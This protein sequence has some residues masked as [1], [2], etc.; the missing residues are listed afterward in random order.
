MTATETLR[1]PLPRIF[2]G[3]ST[4]GLPLAKTLQRL[5]RD[6]AD[7]SLWSD[8]VF[9]LSRAF[10]ESLES[11]LDHADFA[12]MAFT[13]DDV[14]TSRDQAHA[15]PRDNVLF[16]LGLFMGRLGRE[17]CYFVHDKADN[18]KLPSDL[19]G[20]NP[21]NFSLA[22]DGDLAAS[23]EDVVTHIRERLATLGCRPKL[24]DQVLDVFH[25]KQA[26][27][28]AIEG[29]WWQRMLPDTQSALG[30][31]TLKVEPATGN[32]R[33]T[34]RAFALDH[35]PM[36]QWESKGTALNVS[37]RTVFYY[38]TG[39]HPRSPNESFEGFGEMR[40]RQA[41]NTINQGNGLYFDTNLSRVDDTERKS[42]QMR[43]VTAQEKAVMEAGEADPIRALVA[44]TLGSFL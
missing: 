32:V 29:Q 44:Q 12:I 9:K 7:V 35:R 37:A 28:A 19:L 4:E 22:D 26:F 6:D 33:M 14:A 25:Q 8:N 30:Y 38:W 36:A 24:D 41:G 31:V 18:L 17:R 13:A 5:L 2:I 10:M 20:I 23:L 1:T 11:A 34:G 16:E 39:W 3:S 42:F 21:A 40:F 15:I 43:R 27:G